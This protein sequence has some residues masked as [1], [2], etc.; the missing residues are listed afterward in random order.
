MAAFNWKLIFYRRME[1]SALGTTQQLAQTDRSNYTILNWMKPYILRMEIT[2]LSAPSWSHVNYESSSLWIVA[3]F[4][5]P[6]NFVYG[7][8]S[9]PN[10]TKSDELKW[11]GKVQELYVPLHPVV[12]WLPWAQEQEAKRPMPRDDTFSTLKIR[13]SQYIWCSSGAQTLRCGLHSRSPLTHTNAMMSDSRVHFV[14][15]S[16]YE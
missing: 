16:A 3:N 14:C 5:Q 8:Q 6:N 15:A 9:S 11:M 1:R 7:R 2:Q 13:F 4:M 12:V 10:Q